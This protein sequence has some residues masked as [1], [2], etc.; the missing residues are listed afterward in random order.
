MKQRTPEP[1][2]LEEALAHAVANGIVARTPQGTWQHAPFTYWPSPVPRRAYDDALTLAP[3]LNR[4]VAAI[5]EDGQWLR[6]AVREAA[7]VDDFTARILRLVEE[8]PTPPER[9]EV[10][11]AICRFDYFVQ[12]GKLRMVEMNTIAA[13]FAA[14]GAKAARMHRH[15]AVHPATGDD[16]DKCRKEQHPLAAAAAEGIANALADAYQAYVRGAGARGAHTPLCVM[17]VQPGERNTADQNELR[18][19][20]WKLHDIRMVRR[21]LEEVANTGSVQDGVLYIAGRRVALVYARAG[22]SPDDYAGEAQ[23]AARKLI[24]SSDAVKVPTAAVQLAG[25]KVVQQ[26]VGEPDVLQRLLGTRRAALVLPTLAAMHQLTDDNVARACDAPQ[27]FVLKPQREGGGNNLYGD[28]IPAKL[29]VTPRDQRP[30][31]V[32][33]DRI[34]PD[35]A[36]NVMVRD[37]NVT[38]AHVVSELGVFG[39]HLQVHGSV[40]RSDAVGTLLRS[41][42]ADV[43]DGGVAAGVAVLD[44]PYLVD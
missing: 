4:L 35:P 19:L 27:D 21:T 1:E 39:V 33:M 38:A 40:V 11:L 3:V 8:A 32:L 36:Q 28:D 22:Y 12:R 20:V 24:E 15:L 16:F 14:L 30:Q 17:L 25:A 18:A 37:E 43:D 34:I 10:Q 2:G 23:W 13:S 41:K 6:E 26:K 29:A 44:S 42:R 5:V 31:Y 7:R 9:H